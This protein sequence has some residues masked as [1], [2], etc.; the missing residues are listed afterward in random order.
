MPALPI[1]TT[2][3]KQ[4]L[5]L[6]TGFPTLPTQTMQT[7]QP[8]RHLGKPTIPQK[9]ASLEL[10]Q[11]VDRFPRADHRKE[12]FRSNKGTLRTIQLR[13]LQLQ[14]IIK[15]KNALSLVRSCTGQTEDHQNET[16]TN[17]GGC[18]AATFRDISR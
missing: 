11:T 4:T 16:S 3:V 10:R 15:A 8:V 1:I 18:L 17:L 5:T 2:V 6:A 9:N 14:P 13:M 12:R 7:T